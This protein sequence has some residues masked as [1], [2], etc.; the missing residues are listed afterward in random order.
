MREI[1]HNAGEARDVEEDAFALSLAEG[2][3][4]RLQDIDARITAHSRNWNKERI[5]R[6]ALS[7]MRLAVYR[8][9]LCGGYPGQRVH[10]R[11]GGAGSKNTA[12]TRTRP[13]STGCWAASPGRTRPRSFRRHSE[14]SIWGW[15]PATIPLPPPCW[16]AVRAEMR[17][18]KRA[19][20]GEA[21]RDGAASKRRGLPSCAAASRGAGGGT[22]PGGRAAG[23]RGSLRPAAAGGGLVYALLPDGRWRGAGNRGR[24]G[25]SLP[26]VH[27]SAGTCGRRLVRR[28]PPGADRPAVPGLPRLRRNHRRPAGGAGGRSA[29]ALPGGRTLRWISRPANWWIGSAGCW[30]FPSRRGRSWTSWRRRRKGAMIPAPF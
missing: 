19:A 18:A 23:R 29:A 20:A 1:L 22:R 15:I 3:E 30:G 2:A 25:H 17:Q 11:G 16:T 14:S 26:A 4:A 5:S 12:A 7:I 24:G 10:Q 21:G 27:P 8:D 13:S 28:G 6:V 9:A